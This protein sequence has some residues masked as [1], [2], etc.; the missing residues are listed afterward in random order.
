MKLDEKTKKCIPRD[1]Y[2]IVPGGGIKPCDPNCKACKQKADRCTKCDTS[3]KYRLDFARNRCI[4]PLEHY[5][6]TDGVC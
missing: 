6:S 2:Y 4:C 3:K 1:G 5:M